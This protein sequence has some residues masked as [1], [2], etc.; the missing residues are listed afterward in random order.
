MVNLVMQIF[1][2]DTIRHNEHKKTHGTNG[3]IGT[4]KPESA[5]V[6]KVPKQI[7]RKKLNKVDR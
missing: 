2:S 3:S 5:K 7:F 6:S 1:K 4:I